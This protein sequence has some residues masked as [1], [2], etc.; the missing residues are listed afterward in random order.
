MFTSS[1]ISLIVN[2][3]FDRIISLV[4]ST[5]SWI[6]DVEVRPDLSSSLVDSQSL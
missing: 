4:F 1:E 2:R 5:F 3:L 6:F